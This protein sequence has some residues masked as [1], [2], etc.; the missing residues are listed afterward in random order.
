MMIEKIYD[1]I[2][3]IIGQ[4]V[5]YDCR[6]FISQEID[7]NFLDALKLLKNEAMKV[8]VNYQGIVNEIFKKN[9]AKLTD[10]QKNVF[11]I[12]NK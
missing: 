6:I 10:Y 11:I 2:F 8:L 7:K 1:L 5:I 9:K 12:L 4:K 3:E